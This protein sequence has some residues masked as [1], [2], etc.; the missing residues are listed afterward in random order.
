MT[1]KTFE[2]LNTLS[3]IVSLCF[4]YSN[5]Y[6]A[7]GIPYVVQN[8]VFLLLFIYDDFDFSSLVAFIPFSYQVGYVYTYNT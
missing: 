1:L 7:S 2:N 4:I 5:L 3:I 6:F 8:I